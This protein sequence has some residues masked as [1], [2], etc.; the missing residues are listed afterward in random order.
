MFFLVWRFQK[1][2]EHYAGMKGPFYGGECARCSCVHPFALVC[3]DISLH[4]A[5]R[6]WSYAVQGRITSA[7]DDD[8]DLSGANQFFLLFHTGYY[9]A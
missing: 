4:A 3:V 5:S 1:R 2:L 7:F 9:N 8:A 6:A